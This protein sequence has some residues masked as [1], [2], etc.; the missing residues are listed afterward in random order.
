MS[1]LSGCVCSLFFFL[2]QPCLLVFLVILP[3]SHL[4]LN[5]I[6]LLWSDKKA[7]WNKKF[8]APERVQQRLS[9]SRLCANQMHQCWNGKT[10][11]QYTPLTHRHRNT[12]THIH[13]KKIKTCPKNPRDVC[14][15]KKIC[16]TLKN[17]QRKNTALLSHNL[18]PT[19]P[20][21]TADPNVFL[22]IHT[23]RKRITWSA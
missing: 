13:H 23:G 1:P 2:L 8:F 14:T 17:S 11:N 15:K 21:K 7:E 19:L 12:H 6:R 3:M 4:H 5:K 16:L 18:T 9:S 20:L 22:K 10:L